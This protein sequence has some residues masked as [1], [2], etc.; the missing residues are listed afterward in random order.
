MKDE[1]KTR[2]LRSFLFDFRSWGVRKTIGL[3]PASEAACGYGSCLGL[4]R[5]AAHGV[6][7]GG[8]VVM[9]RDYKLFWILALGSEK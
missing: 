5:V 8:E 6:W 1:K 2:I 4:P 3:Q 9:V 7:Q